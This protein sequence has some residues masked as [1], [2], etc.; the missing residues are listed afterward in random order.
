MYRRGLTVLT[1]GLDHGVLLVD[2]ERSKMVLYNHL[3]T[4]PNGFYTT[5]LERSKMGFIHSPWNVRSSNAP[6]ELYVIRQ[7]IVCYVLDR[8]DRYENSFRKN[9]RRIIF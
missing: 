9:S 7:S 2:R 1:D 6:I 5:T 8:F 4:F 3:V